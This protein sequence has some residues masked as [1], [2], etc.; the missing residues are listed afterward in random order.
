MDDEVFADLVKVLKDASSALKSKNVNELYELSNHTIHNSSIFQDKDS[1][2]VAVLIYSL[3]KIIKRQDLKNFS[4][5]IT[6]INSCYNCLREKKFH[7]YE[8]EIERL[9]NLIRHEDRNLGLYIMKIANEA[10]IKKGSKI[11]DHGISIA[12]AAE[13][14]GISQWEL[15]NYV[16][17]INLD[18]YEN[19]DIEKRLEFTRGLF[20]L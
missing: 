2:R 15:M 7:K 18:Q 6:H 20:R 4:R 8:K 9:F 14:L 3:S 16:G 19:E 10:A 11:Y 1:V 12:R 13:I 17:K 5:I